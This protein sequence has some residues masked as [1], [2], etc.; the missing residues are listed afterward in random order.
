[1]GRSEKKKGLPRKQFQLQVPPNKTAREPPVP[2][3]VPHKGTVSLFQIV[4]L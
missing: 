1:M 3:P 4:G 2:A